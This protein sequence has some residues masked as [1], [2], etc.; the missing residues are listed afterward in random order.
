[1][2]TDGMTW[3]GVAAFLAAG[4]AAACL[5]L[6][7]AG[8]AVTRHPR[9]AL[10]TVAL[11]LL[12]AGV[13][14]LLLFGASAASRESVL[15]V[16]AE[17]HLCALDCH[18]AYS[19]QSTDRTDGQLVTHLRVR[20]DPETI[21]PRRGDAPLAASTTAVCLLEG[22]GGCRPAAE[23]SHPF[24]R[25][26]RPGEA[27]TVT[28]TF[29]LTGAGTPVGLDVYDDFP[30]DRLIIGHERSLGHRDALLAVSS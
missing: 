12:G 21:S 7:A 10:G 19:V 25:S 9:I 14:G 3:F 28:L 23:G 24:T 15:A 6:V 8:A 26:L 27:Y 5:V 29:D 20:F 4:A 22:A 2:V 17:K 1:M 13:Y 30:A 11:L 18:L 16:G